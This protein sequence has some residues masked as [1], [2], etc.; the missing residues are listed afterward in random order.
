[1]QWGAK[2]SAINQLEA[3]ERKSASERLSTAT[4][5]VAIGKYFGEGFDLLRLDTLFLAMPIAWKGALAKYTC[6][7]QREVDGKTLV[8]IHDYVDSYIP[9]LQCMFSKR[10]KSDKS[11]GYEWRLLIVVLLLWFNV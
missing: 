5:V 7:I 9:M 6:R 4:F 2:L 11:M 3:A 8:T 10:D 1:M